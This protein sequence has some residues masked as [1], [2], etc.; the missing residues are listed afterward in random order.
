VVQVHGG[1]SG[2]DP[3]SGP[4]FRSSHLGPQLGHGPGQIQGRTNCPLGVVLG[5]DRSSPHGHHRIADELLYGAA[6]AGDQGAASVE[7]AGQQIADLLGVARLRE[8]G[9]PDQIGE[10]DKDEAALGGGALT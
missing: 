6:V 10:Q 4:K 2:E 3:G 8:R 1:L 9:E 5:G 7:V